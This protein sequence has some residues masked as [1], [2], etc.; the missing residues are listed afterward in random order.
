MSEKEM[1]SYVVERDIDLVFVQLLQTSPKF[2]DWFFNQLDLDEPVNEFLGTRHSVMTS[3]GESDIEVGFKTS[4]GQCTIVLIENKIDEA[5]QDRQ[6]ERYFERGE[7]YLS[8]EDWD[9]FEVCLTAP[10]NYVTGNKNQGF[11]TIVSYEDSINQIQS[12]EH[13]GKDFF[14]VM[15]R[16]A[17]AKRV[18]ADHSDMTAAIRQGILSKIEELPRVKHYKVSNTQ[19]RLESTHKRHPSAV[20]YNVYIPGPHDGN[21]AIVRINLTGRDGVSEA[22]R[23][24]LLPIFLEQLNQPEG[25][26]KRDRPMDVVRKEIYRNDFESQDE[27]INQIVIEVCDL[28]RYYHPRLVEEAS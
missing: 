1:L 6:V 23:E 4:S 24:S 16:E 27:Y 2:R 22:T 9:T 28:I 10:E 20:L 26:E 11:D 19:V 3:N 7:F 15:F 8:N 12:I 13:D 25:Y 17:L 14:L 18:A 5:L 21:R